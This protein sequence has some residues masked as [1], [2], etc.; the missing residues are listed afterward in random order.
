MTTTTLAASLVGLILSVLIIRRLWLAACV[1]QY[2]FNALYFCQRNKL[3][4]HVADEMSQLWPISHM[5]MEIWHW[6][7]SRYVI[8]QDHLEAMNAFIAEE[9]ER[10]DLDLDQLNRENDQSGEPPQGGPS[11]D[12]P[13]GST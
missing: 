5:I 2:G 8:H 3:P 1:E 12:S 4:I 11:D 7:F 10:K 6:D 9:K 13:A